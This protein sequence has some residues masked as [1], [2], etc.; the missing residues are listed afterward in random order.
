MPSPSSSTQ[1]VLGSLSAALRSRDSL[2]SSS[3][4]PRSP[5]STASLPS[6]TD[7]GSSSSASC[8]SLTSLTSSRPAPNEHL[9]VLL[10]R[11]LWK[12]D[13]DAPYCD[14]FVCSK[15]F[16]LMERRHVRVLHAFARLPHSNLNLS[17]IV[18]S[19]VVSFARPALRALPLCLTPLPC[20]SSTPHAVRRYLPTRHQ[21]LPSYPHAFVTR[22]M[23]KSTAILPRARRRL[24][25]APRCRSP[26][27]LV[28]DLLFHAVPVL[29]PF[30]H[31]H[32]ILH[33]PMTCAATHFGSVPISAKRLAEAGGRPNLHRFL[34]T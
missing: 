1:S 3:S 7:S 32:R 14:T 33:S 28:Q 5:A 8:S 17:S 10:S 15:P 11:D 23:H 12:Q 22:A 25:P 27:R 18:E 30:H 4:I 20:P 26:C 16:T 21:P 6:L 34:T 24:L 31:R 29:S 19:V 13:T 2:A 9:A